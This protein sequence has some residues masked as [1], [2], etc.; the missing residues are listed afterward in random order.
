MITNFWTKTT[1]FK[2]FGKTFFSKEEICN[3][4]EYEG[5]VIEVQVPAEYYKSEFDLKKN[6]KKKQ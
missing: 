1:N 2:L 6:E 3:E 4:K 5:Q